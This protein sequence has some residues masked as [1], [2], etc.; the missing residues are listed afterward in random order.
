MKFNIITLICLLILYHSNQSLAQYLCG[1]V[2]TNEQK[3][4]IKKQLGKLKEIDLTNARM[5]TYNIAVKA[6]IVRR[7]DGSGGLSPADLNAAIVTLNQIY[8]PTGLVFTQ[9]GAINYIDNTSYYDFTPSEESG[10]ATNNDIPNVINI[11][12]LNSITKNGDPLCGYTRF[13]PSVDRIFMTNFCATNGATLAHEVG[14]YFT[15]YHTHGKTNCGPMTD[16]LVDGSNCSTAGDDICDTPA[17]PNLYG[18]NCSGSLLNNCNYVGILTDANGDFFSPMVENIMSYSFSCRSAFTQGQFTRI[19]SGYLTGRNYLSDC[20]SANAVFSG[21]TIPSG[22]IVD[23][24]VEYFIMASNYLIEPNA[25]VR[26]DAGGA[27]LLL[28]NFETQ[29]GA[30][31]LGVIDGCEGNFKTN[32]YDFDGAEIIPDMLNITTYPNPFSTQ[33]TIAYN[34]SNEQNVSLSILSTTGQ[35]IVN[36]LDNTIQSAGKHE[37]QFNGQDLPKGMYFYRFIDGTGNSH[38]GKMMLVD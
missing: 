28:P 15:L 23:Q 30:N 38:M 25:S 12:F 9:C 32:N 33:T 13:P 11:Y 34:L 35:E 8:A 31:F 2:A 16:E 5:Q 4:F 27:V 20:C 18:I 7:D 21:V 19:L 14:H 6:H 10:L 29:V 1:T 17:D 37:I 24:E 36:L 22:G 3:S 26:F